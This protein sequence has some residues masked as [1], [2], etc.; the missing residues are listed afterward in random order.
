M[1]STAGILKRLK[2]FL[3]D[4]RFRIGND[5]SLILPQIPFINIEKTFRPEFL[6]PSFK[7]YL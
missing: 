6:D 5:P 2:N 4:N 7:A 1:S 3:T